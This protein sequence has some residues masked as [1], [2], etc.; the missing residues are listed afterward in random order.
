[1]EKPLFPI[2]LKLER[3]KC[4]VIGAGKIA[5]GK[6]AGL[7]CS[8]ARV[9]VIAPQATRWIESQARAG[10]LQWQQREFKAADVRGAFLVVAATNSGAINRSVFRACKKLRVL[11]NAVDDPPHC[12]FFYP[13]VV[14]RGPLQIAIS[15]GGRSPALAHRLRTELE[16]QFGPEYALWVEQVGKMREEILHQDLSGEERRMSL[17][18]IASQESWEQ[19]RSKRE[20]AKRQPQKKQPARARRSSKERTA[21]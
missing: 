7:L 14:R 20:S 13:A 16:Q 17:A 21:D 19:F 15:T 4:V 1:V 18:A 10:K 2:F 5:E 6:A 12:D 9:V 3:R 11:C 8:Q